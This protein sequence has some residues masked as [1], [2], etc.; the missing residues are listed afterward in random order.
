MSLAAVTVANAAPTLPQEPAHEATDRGAGSKFADLL[1]T[2]T[3]E[4][5]QVET[6]SKDATS[7]GTTAPS[8]ASNREADKA[9]RLAALKAALA[10]L[11]NDGLGG[12]ANADLA[13]TNASTSS[14]PT[15][16]APKSRQTPN[17]DAL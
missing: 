6:S 15:T 2:L 12:G 9:S 13:A 7:D 1:N 4:T 8:A 10:S 17:S 5:T 11:A 16:I 14:K 3:R